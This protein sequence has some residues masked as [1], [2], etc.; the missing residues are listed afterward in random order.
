MIPKLIHKI[1]LGPNPDPSTFSDDWQ[2]LF[3]NHQIIHWDNCSLEPY[4]DKVD[5]LLNG[6]PSITI[7]SA[8]DI[9]RLLILQ[10]HGGIYL[11]HDIQIVK[12]FEH[13]LVDSDAFA[14]FQFPPSPCRAYYKP[15]TTLIDIIGSTQRTHEFEKKHDDYI[16]GE[17]N[18]S[19][20]INTTDY[21]NNCFIASIPH[22]KFIEL[23]IDCWVKNYNR[24]DELKYP[25]SDWGCGPATMSDA[26]RQL[27]IELTGETQSTPSL[28]VYHMRH[29]HP[30]NGCMRMEDENKLNDLIEQNKSLDDCY[31]IHH[32]VYTGAPE[33][34]NS[35][36]DNK[37][38][39]QY[40]YSYQ[41]FIKLLRQS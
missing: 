29:F 7:T 24:P 34:V 22:S 23:A 1:W 9:L 13:M 10:D 32:G 36:F 37:D 17:L 16:T 28:A 5:E 21:V 4:F 31:T 35:F 6:T 8:S 3:P 18:D 30:V 38:H 27:G 20:F 2:R 33:F 11:D 14:T 25:F 19:Q 39:D 12:N 40:R 41:S 15:G 26:A